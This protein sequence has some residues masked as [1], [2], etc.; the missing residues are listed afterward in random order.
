MANRSIL[1]AALG[2]AFLAAATASS[3]VAIPASGGPGPS[4]MTD[5]TPVVD[6]DNG[7]ISVEWIVVATVEYDPDA[8]PWIKTLLAP[9]VDITA[10]TVLLFSET[11]T[12]GGTVP[13]TDW[14]EILPDGFEW[15]GGVVCLGPCNPDDPPVGGEVS[16]DGGTIV[17]EFDP[18][19]SGTDIFISKEFRFTATGTAVLPIQVREFP[20]VEVGEPASLALM[21][22]GLLAL[23]FARRRRAR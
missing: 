20:T 13:W 6:E 9:G 23:G 22:A 16:V 1:A 11:I 19:E 14:H 18:V 21:G 3:A 15:V 12:I 5:V 10:Q 8:G 17:F 2:A 4:T 7:V